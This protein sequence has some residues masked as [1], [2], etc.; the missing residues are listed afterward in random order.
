MKKNKKGRGSKKRK[1]ER[2]GLI[3]RSVITWQPCLRTRQAKN[4]ACMIYA[5]ES[6][7][8]TNQASQQLVSP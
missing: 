4:P 5:L 3:I 7:S 6:A 2:T 8:P 1:G